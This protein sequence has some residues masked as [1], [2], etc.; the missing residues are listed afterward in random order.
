MLYSFILEVIIF[1][2]LG[3]IIVIL[4]RALPRV[5]SEV[6]TNPSRENKFLLFCKKIPLDKID[7]YLNLA[8]HKSLRKLKII[9]MKADNFITKKLKSMRSNSNKKNGTGLPI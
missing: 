6:N 8:L 5:E 9:I 1:L 2:G 3:V 4:A 7:N